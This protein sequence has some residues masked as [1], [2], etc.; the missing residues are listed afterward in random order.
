MAQEEGTDFKGLA[1]STDNLTQGDHLSRR[2]FKAVGLLA[3]P[4][5]P[6]C[7]SEPYGYLCD[8]SYFEIAGEMNGQE[9]KLG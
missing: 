7:Q 2:L 6:F 9:E 3:F 5:L 8:P 1:G 4:L